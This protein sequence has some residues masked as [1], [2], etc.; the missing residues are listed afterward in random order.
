[1]KS[2]EYKQLFCVDL[3]EHLCN[4]LSSQM[5]GFS[6]VYPR[7]AIG[8]NRWVCSSNTLEE[9]G[10]L[11]TIIIRPIINFICTF[12]QPRWLLTAISIISTDYI[13]YLMQNMPDNLEHIWTMT[14]ESACR[15]YFCFITNLLRFVSDGFRCLLFGMFNLLIEKGRIPTDSQAPYLYTCLHRLCKKIL[16]LV[17]RMDKQVLERHRFR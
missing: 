13:N 4:G 3:R 10:S 12:Q 2:T 7:K 17:E 14:F 11:I 15:N 9:E 1:M 8:F 6:N 5:S 16:D